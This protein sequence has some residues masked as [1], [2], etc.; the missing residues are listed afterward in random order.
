MRQSPIN[1]NRQED[2]RKH[3]I[4]GSEA[5]E[6][7]QGRAALRRIF[8]RS[9]SVNPVGEADSDGKEGGS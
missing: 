6:D 7:R 2:E 8:D 9:T 4:N 5:Q 3:S 1:E